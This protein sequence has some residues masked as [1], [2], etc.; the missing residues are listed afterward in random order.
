MG[1]NVGPHIKAQEQASRHDAPG[2]R[3]VPLR[4]A[5]YPSSGTS[6]ATETTPPNCERDGKPPDQTPHLHDHAR[7]RPVTV[8]SPYARQLANPIGLGPHQWFQ[9]EHRATPVPVR[10]SPVHIDGSPIPC[11]TLPD[12]VSIAAHKSGLDVQDDALRSS[13]LRSSPISA[14]ATSVISPESCSTNSARLSCGNIRHC[15]SRS[16]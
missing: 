16:S 12:P 3:S 11:S 9:S 10:R 14:K 13:P 4:P 5:T 2:H 6:R 1:F 15:A 7:P 8:Q